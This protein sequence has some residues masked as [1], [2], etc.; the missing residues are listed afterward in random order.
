MLTGY[1]LRGLTLCCASLLCLQPGCTSISIE[2]SCPT[3]LRVGESGP[4]EANEQNPGGIPAY[5][6]EVLPPQAGTFTNP[7]APNATFQALQ[8][9]DLVVRLTASDGLYQVVSECRVVVAGTIDIAVSLSASPNPVLVGETVT[10]QCTSV[11]AETVS[12]SIVQTDGP[13]VE[14]NPVSEGEA[15]FTAGEEGEL[16]FRCIGEGPGE[17]PSAPSFVTVEVEELPGNGNDNGNANANDNGN[18]N[19]NDNENDNGDGN[20]NVNG[21]ENG[22]DNENDNA[23]GNDN[24]NDDANGNDNGTTPDNENENDT[25]NDNRDKK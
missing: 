21:N 11:G 17:I 22:N 9:G 14:L 6:W 3:E 15:T 18:D 7:S 13:M 23:D 2:P 20:D 1:R 4:V 25:G 19:G 24:G 16:E 5:R 8:E 12:P 10:L